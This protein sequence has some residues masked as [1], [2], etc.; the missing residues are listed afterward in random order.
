VAHDP[1]IGDVIERSR[2]FRGRDV[3]TS[4]LS[5][6]HVNKAYVVQVGDVRYVVRIP[7]ASSELLVPDRANERH[8]TVAAATSGVSPHVVEY[9]DDWQVMVLEYVQGETLTDETIGMGDR[10]PRVAGMLRTLHAGPRFRTDFDMFRTAERWLRICNEREIAIPLG[11]PERMDQVHM[12]ARALAVLAMDSVPSH[13]DLSSDNIID[14]G[15]RLWLIDF[16]YSG[17]NDPCYDIADLASQASLD[18]D[19]RAVLCE[20][21]FGVADPALL[22]RMRLHSTIADIGWAVW[23][24][25]QLRVSSREIDFARIVKA[26]W[27]QARAMLD[28]EEF[29]RLMH[30]ASGGRVSN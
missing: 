29:P 12:A 16:E 15:R 2:L 11:L 4:R 13:N 23:A 6:G 20:A 17:N 19:R 14:D 27:D 7:G 18:D 5:G 8:D 21:Y 24:S 26:F 9:L 25:I 28:S 10:I 1:T 3:A 30:A 22:A